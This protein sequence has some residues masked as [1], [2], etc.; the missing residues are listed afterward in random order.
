MFNSWLTAA[1]AEIDSLKKQLK[2]YEE[3]IEQQQQQ[4]ELNNVDSKVLPSNTMNFRVF[5]RV[6]P[7]F[8][9]EANRTQCKWQFDKASLKIGE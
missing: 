2:K 1:T 4:K 8:E 6:R 7:A 5:C 9:K 3:K